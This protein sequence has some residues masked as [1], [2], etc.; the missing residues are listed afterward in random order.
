MKN[1]EKI[2]RNKP[3]D[4]SFGFYPP[5]PKR[6]AHPRT[7]NPIQKNKKIEN[8]VLTNE[9]NGSIMLKVSGG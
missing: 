8:E 5:H 7:G 1:N 9:K 4:L 6:L 2:P 3:R